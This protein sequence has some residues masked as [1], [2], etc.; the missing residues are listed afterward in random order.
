MDQLQAGL[1]SHVALHLCRHDGHTTPA[2]VLYSMLWLQMLLHSFHP[3]RVVLDSLQTTAVGEQGM[4][5]FTQER[6]FSSTMVFMWGMRIG[7]T[8]NS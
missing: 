6:S 5:S 1:D 8:M 3:S 7:R 4:D 2:E